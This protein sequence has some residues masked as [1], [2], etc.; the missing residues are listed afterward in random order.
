MISMGISMAE[1]FHTSTEAVAEHIADSIL[2][3]N[4][5]M[6]KV[7]AFLKEHAE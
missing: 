2:T 7:T 6:A 1:S 5:Q 3:E 4:I